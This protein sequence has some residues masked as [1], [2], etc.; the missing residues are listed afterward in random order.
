MQVGTPEYD[1]ALGDIMDH[2]RVHNDSEENTDLPM[3]VEKIGNDAAKDAAVRF[4]RTK[5]FAPTQFVFSSCIDLRS[6]YTTICSPHPSAPNKP[7][8]ETFVGL[9]TAPIDKLRDAFEQ[10]PSDEE[11]TAAAKN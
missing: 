4:K 11:K 3:L 6:T 5:K 10:F 2:L 1:N 9:M 8:F 7:P